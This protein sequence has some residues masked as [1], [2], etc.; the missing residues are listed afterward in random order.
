MRPLLLSLILAV[1]CSLCGLLLFTLKPVQADSIVTRAGVP[2]QPT[3]WNKQLIFPKFN[4]A[5]GKL[6]SVEISV[7]ATVSGD[8]AYENK[9]PISATV[10]LSLTAYLRLQRPNQTDLYTILPQAIV[11]ESAAPFDL[12]DDFAGASGRRQSVH[13]TD[14]Q[15]GVF[16]DPADLALFTGVGDLILNALATGT[17]SVQGPGNIRSEVRSQAAALVVVLKYNYVNPAIDLQKTVYSGYNNGANC[18][19]QEVA[20]GAPGTPVTY[21]FVITNRGN[22]YLHNLVFTDTNLGIDLNDLQL[23]SGSLPLAPAARLF[24]FYTGTI[25]I[26]LLNTAAVEA[27]PTDAAGGDIPGLN[28]VRDTDTARIELISAA[29]RLDK[30][31]YRG[32]NNGASCPGVDLVG[33]L[34]GA[35][36]TYCFKVTNT[37]SV[38]LD[39]IVITDTTLS[40]KTANLKLVSGVQPLAPGASLVYFYTS[41]LT[42]GLVNTA[43]TEGN[44][45]D[46]AGR[47]LPGL[48]NPKDDD[49]AEVAVIQ[50]AAV[51]DFVWLDMVNLNGLQDAQEPGLN[52]VTVILLDENGTATG[53]QTVTSNQP[54]SGKAGWYE[55]RDLRPGKYQVEFINP[56][57]NK[58][59]FTVY[60]QSQNGADTLDSDADK[61][62][63]R[64]VVFSLASGQ[65]DLTRDAGL[66]APTALQQLP[67][68]ASPGSAQAIYLPMIQTH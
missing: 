8:M 7:T 32:Q 28:N 62:S 34:P 42:T 19:G 46:A 55:F 18:P 63:G 30:T 5:L 15:Q 24:Y 12:Q 20:V 17:S 9:D 35:P 6:T 39:S 26:P 49:S 65:T 54:N 48:P 68:P 10:L 22:T 25:Q 67:E 36:L 44:P 45:T 21:C 66:I 3:D 57:I 61:R 27:N 59:A 58:Y 11:T 37:G 60:D 40:L 31:V 51:G 56:D 50:P 33:D 29:I 64:T 52:G 2:L 14:T 38:H 13:K 43:L 23:I 41:T 4:P 1:A 47:D 16:T 53:K